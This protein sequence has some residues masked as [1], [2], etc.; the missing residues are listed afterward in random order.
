MSEHKAA[1]GT[2]RGL[3][4]VVKSRA[5]PAPG[6]NEILIQVKAIAV[7]PVDYIM[8]DMGFQVGSWPVVLGSDLSGIIVKT[9][10]NASAGFKEGD[11]VLANA[12]AFDKKGA[13]N[14][15]AF[16]EYA[17]VPQEAVTPIPADLTFQEAAILPLAIFTTT[18]GYFH[19]LKVPRQGYKPEDKKAMLVWGAGGSIGTVAVQVAKLLGFTVYA[20]A[21]KSHHTYLKQLGAHKCFDYKDTDVVTNVVNAI[22]EDGFVLDQVFIHLIDLLRFTNITFHWLAKVASAPFSFKM[23]W[24]KLYRWNGVAVE[25]VAP[26]EG[27]ARDDFFQFTF[28]QWAKEKLAQKLLVPSPRIELVPGGL[29]AVQGALDKLKAGV[30][31]IKFVVEL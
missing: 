13:E 23:M 27:K 2:G 21:S 8:R 20:T 28:N 15:G 19:T 26:P 4:L 29:S 1:V 18:T 30:S 16:Q 10:S 31:G 9:G 6:P 14:Y 24:W 7:N 11:R 17:L 25:F 5:T 22:K 3:P 12:P